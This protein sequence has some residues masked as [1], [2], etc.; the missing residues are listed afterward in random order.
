MNKVINMKNASW[1]VKGLKAKFKSTVPG[2]GIYNEESLF[3]SNDG[4][5]P[6]T[7]HTKSAA[8]EIAQYAKGFVGYYWIAVD[9]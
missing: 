7:Y 8:V 3:L 1:T 6:A 9:V 5:T 2:F 4:V